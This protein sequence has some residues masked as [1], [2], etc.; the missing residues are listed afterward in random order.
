MI[1]GCVRLVSSDYSDMGLVV[2]LAPRG[3]AKYLDGQPHDD[4]YWFRVWGMR[5]LLWAW[6][7]L[8]IDAVTTGVGDESWRVREMTAKVVARHL[9]GEALPAMAELRSDPVPRVR[10][11]AERAIAALSR[12]VA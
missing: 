4:V 5:G 1:A 2:A 7:A 11:A 6:D 12:A 8:A 3:S 10:A 9:I